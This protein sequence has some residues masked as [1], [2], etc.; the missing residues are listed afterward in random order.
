[1]KLDGIRR[2]RHRRDG[3]TVRVGL[4]APTAG[5]EGRREDLFDDVDLSRRPPSMRR[6][7]ALDPGWDVGRG[8]R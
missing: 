3:S 2:T 1:M 4:G 7:V 8:V 5:A 6:L